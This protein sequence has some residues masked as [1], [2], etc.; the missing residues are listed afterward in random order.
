MTPT[1]GLPFSRDPGSSTSS[2]ASGSASSA[3][4]ARWAATLTS[5]R[6]S[7]AVDIG[8]V[9]VLGGR[10]LDDEVVRR[11]ERRKRRRRPRHVD[12]RL[13]R[14]GQKAGG[15]HGG[16]AQ[17]MGGPAPRG[18]R[19]TEQAGEHATPAGPLRARLDRVQHAD[20]PHGVAG[21]G[22]AQPDLGERRVAKQVEHALLAGGQAPV[23]VARALAQLELAHLVHH[24]RQPGLRIHLPDPSRCRRGA[25]TRPRDLPAGSDVTPAPWTFTRRHLSRRGMRRAACHRQDRLHKRHP[26]S[27]SRRAVPDGDDRDQPDPC[28][29][30]SNARRATCTTAYPNA[31]LGAASRRRLADAARAPTDRPGRESRRGGE[32]QAR[33]SRVER[34]RHHARRARGLRESHLRAARRQRRPE[35]QQQLGGDLSRRGVSPRLVRRRRR[36]PHD[37][38]AELHRLPSPRSASRIR[39]WTRRRGLAAPAGPRRT[40]SR[41]AAPG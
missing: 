5:P 25:A 31:A 35:D 36:S 12:D 40:R 19:G 7:A 34:P 9:R 1:R 13:L 3:A 26:D 21:R 16:A 33:R 29:S 28:S 8:P 2:T 23:G 27:T 37:L 30:F 14:A 39:R 32:R 15:Q 4:S 41:S 17:H 24:P 22:D 38:P 18:H 6:R 10:P 20:D 11:G